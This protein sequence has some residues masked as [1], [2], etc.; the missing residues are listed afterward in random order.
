MTILAIVVAA[1]VFFM[2]AGC[3]IIGLCEMADSKPQ[4]ETKPMS[5][6]MRVIQ[7]IP[8]D[9]LATGIRRAFIVSIEHGPTVLIHQGVPIT[10]SEHSTPYEAEKRWTATA[11]MYER[12]E[13]CNGK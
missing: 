2:L 13:V 7:T 12:R 11:A 10:V 3:A 6:S 5:K 8:G 1:L 9:S 4:Q